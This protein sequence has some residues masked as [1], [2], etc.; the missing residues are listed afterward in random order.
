MLR[1][2]LVV[3]LLCSLAWIPSS[4]A[5]A[6]DGNPEVGKVVGFAVSAAARD[7]P[8]AGS[9][10]KAEGAEW[11]REN[12]RLP[13]SLNPKSGD[14]ADEAL[15]RPLET[16]QTAMPPT[17]VS[18]DGLSSQDNFNAFGG[19]VYPPDTNGAVGP[20]HYM[21]QTNLLVRVWD[22]TG[23]PLVAPFKLSSLFTSLGGQCSVQDAGDPIVL[24]DQMA[25]RWVLSQ[26]AYANFN[27]PPYHECIAVSTTADPTGTYYLYDFITPGNEFPDYPKLG[28]WPDGY[29]MTTN[30][31]LNGGSFDGA[32]VFA[33][34]RVKMLRGDP[35][36][37]LLYF[38][39][40]L[41]AHPEGIGGML[42]SSLDGLKLPPA[43]APNTFAYFT[44]TLWGDPSN[45][46]RLFDFHADF[47]SPASST[48]TE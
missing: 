46:L 13:K 22:K 9:P 34:D 1:R 33:F 41:A 14:V 36:A 26:F 17:I 38:N 48:F 47:A 11:E 32:G 45:A 5:R 6:A 24:Y 23:S 12:D 25:D 42:P 7:L 30:Q 39:L 4:S 3:G 18:F 20:D 40:S 8:T 44:A 27:A 21:Q 43:G 2:T 10:L 35:T 31:F 15:Q 28:V 37:T 19:R 29:Y 16:P